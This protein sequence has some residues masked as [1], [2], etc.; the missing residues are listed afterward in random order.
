MQVWFNLPAASE[1]F[2]KS[3]YV[4]ARNFVACC[5]SKMLVKPLHFCCHH[6]A[7]RNLQQCPELRFLL[8]HRH[9]LWKTVRRNGEGQGTIQVLVSWLIT[10]RSVVRAGAP[11][12]IFSP[13]ASLLSCHLQNNST[14]VDNI[15]SGQMIGVVGAIYSVFPYFVCAVQCFVN[16]HFCD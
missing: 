4:W 10:G 7:C 16:M 6:A 2:C 13:C 3:L 1:M 11:I 12:F 8:T 15:K 5:R 14:H 9:K